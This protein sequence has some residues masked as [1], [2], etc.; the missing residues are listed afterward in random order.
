MDL[1]VNNKKLGSIFGELTPLKM[2]QQL[3]RFKQEDELWKTTIPVVQ[4]NYIFG[5]ELEMENITRPMAEAS[6]ES[7]WSAT[8]DNSLRNNG[9]EFVS[10]PLKAFQI[11]Y[12]LD[13]IQSLNPKYQPVFSERTSTHVHMNVRD[14]TMDQ[15]IGLVLT[16]IAVEKALFK[17]VG[18]DRDKNI[19]CIPL[20][21]TDYFTLIRDLLK[22]PQST[23]RNWEKYSALNL[24]PLSSKGTVE[25]RH[26][27]GTWN[28]Q[29]ILRWT[30]LLSYLKMYA[31]KNTLQDIFKTITNLNSNSLY[32]DFIYQVFK[33]HADIVLR[34][35]GNLQALLEDSITYCK[36]V[37][38]T[39]QPIQLGTGIDWEQAVANI[40]A[41]ARAATA[42]VGIRTMP[43]R[44]DTNYPAGPANTRRPGS[45]LY[46][47]TLPS[48]NRPRW[49]ATSLPLSAPGWLDNNVPTNR[50]A[51]NPVSWLN[52]F[53]QLIFSTKVT[54]FPKQH[55]SAQEVTWRDVVNYLRDGKRMGSLDEGQY[56][57]LINV[58]R[59]FLNFWNIYNNE[60]H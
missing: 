12:A 31:K 27:A 47:R 24:L 33:S 60:E 13:Q 19:F 55:V 39:V 17:V 23:L 1:P 49:T 16:Y 46:H 11:E 53:G 30:N 26:L 40:P 29:E 34:A 36:L 51:E 5:I 8:T 43:P 44:D 25:F 20:N 4:Q 3:E 50:D 56:E 14:M 6:Y 38:Y 28:K 58:W 32:E 18:H 2:T 42:T 7:Y 22:N 48:N 54:Y 35:A 10:V 37:I 52:S 57:L 9:V 15:I 59:D 45:N 21:N 41:P